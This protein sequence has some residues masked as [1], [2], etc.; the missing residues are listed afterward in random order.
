MPPL[1]GCGMSGSTTVKTLDVRIRQFQHILGS[2][3]PAGH[4]PN[5]AVVIEARLGFRVRR[6]R[7]VL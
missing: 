6:A 5:R 3:S 7:H 2:V 4:N 1:F